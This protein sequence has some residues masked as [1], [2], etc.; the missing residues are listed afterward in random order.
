MNY[1]FKYNLSSDDLSEVK[2]FYKKLDHV[3]LEQY[4]GW[5][6]VIDSKDRICFF[7]AQENK[8]IVCFAQIIESGRLFK[9]ARIQFG[10]IF[11]NANVLIESLL[12]IHNYYYRNN[13]IYLLVQLGIPTGFIADYI[14][15]KINKYFKIKY[16]FN[17]ENCW[18]SLYI[19]LSCEPEEIFKKFSKGHKCAIKKAEKE[20][21]AIL[22]GNDA[23][24]IH[25]FC[26]V[27]LKM[28]DQRKLPISNET[29]VF[30]RIIGFLE[31]TKQ[32]F[33]LAVADCKEQILGGIILV[34][35]GSTVRYYKGAA[36]PSINIPVLHLAI[37]EAIKKSKLMGF[38]Y[39][40]LWGYN[41]F[42]EKGS[43]ASNVNIFKKGFSGDY[44]FYPKMMQ[45]KL[46]PIR[47]IVYSILRVIK[48][49]ILK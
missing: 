39:F 24:R 18:S 41:F 4:P 21:V 15:Y 33:F 36:D 2:T 23:S 46:K 19:D 17:S 44:I 25:D 48:S 26:K 43:Q 11:N 14:E 27:Y 13:F 35:Q 1:Y 37:Y 49:K 6:S 31:K 42:A 3:S 47:H 40:D 7:L 10:P 38:K 12:Q 22:E 8:E 29:R 32:G 28:K 9:K 30:P 20:G 34:F 16:Y 5:Y 45:F